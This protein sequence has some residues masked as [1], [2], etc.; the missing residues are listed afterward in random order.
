MVKTL[1]PIAGALAFLIIAGF[2]TS[3]LTVELFGARDQIIWL[4]TTLPWAFVL[5]IP[6]LALTGA[7]GF[8]RAGKRCGGVIGAKARRMPWIAAN[9]LLILVPS[10]LILAARA[11]EG[12][13]DTLFYAVQGIELVF[14]AVNLTLL[15]LS[16]R[17]GLRLSGRLRRPI[18]R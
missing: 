8:A 11:A 10:A 12:Q 2:W 18:V 7:T 9:G 3:T 6:A 13:L 15:G 4:K 5:L 1:H 14:G 17:D 16:L